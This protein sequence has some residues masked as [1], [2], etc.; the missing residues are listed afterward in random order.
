MIKLAVAF[1]LVFIAGYLLC[2]YQDYILDIL[3]HVFS[4]VLTA[5]YYWLTGIMEAV[6]ATQTD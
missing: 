2:A 4:Y 6:S 3:K 5:L 1:L